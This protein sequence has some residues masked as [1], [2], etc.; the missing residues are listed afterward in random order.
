MRP[1]TDVAA[2][3]VLLKEG[4]RPASSSTAQMTRRWFSHWWRKKWLLLVCLGCFLIYLSLA[5]FRGPRQTK[6]VPGN[7]NIHRNM[8]EFLAEKNKNIVTNRVTFVTSHPHLTNKP[9]TYEPPFTTIPETQSSHQVEAS[10]TVNPL[11]TT[12][13]SLETNT[14]FNSILSIISRLASGKQLSAKTTY[15]ALKRPSVSQI[16][17]HVKD[18]SSLVPAYLS[19][20][21]RTGVELVLGIPTVKRPKQNYLR[22]TLKRLLGTMSP[23]EKNRT[24]IVILIAEVDKR[25]VSR[26]V[27][28][29]HTTFSGD[30][31]SGLIDIVSPPGSFYPDF[32][33]LPRATGIGDDLQR[34]TWRS[35]QNLDYGFLMMFALDRGRYY[36]QL[37]DDVL[38]KNGFVSTVLQFAAEKT[39]TNPEWIICDFCELGF[40]GKLFKSTDLAWLVE[41]FLIF[42]KDQPCDWLIMRAIL[43]K[44]C[45]FDEPSQKC[46]ARKNQVWLSHSNSLFQ[47]IG[48]ISSLPGKIQKLKSEHFG[49]LQLFKPHK[50]PEANTQTSISEI[51]GTYHTIDAAYRGRNFFWGREP[52]SKDYI[53][54]RFKRP[55]NL[56]RYFLQSGN[57]EHPSDQFYETDVVVYPENGAGPISIGSF[58]GEGIASGLVPN[59]VNPITEFKLEVRKNSENDV[60]LSEILLET[61][62]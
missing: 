20:K 42:F 58:D 29:I 35:K 11:V 44:V 55:I 45:R 18:D 21:G 34:F 27:G 22:V 6:I 33:A 12:E 54:F 49:K 56:T 25:F 2:K 40:I 36:M 59:E 5:S 23:A 4:H 37:E 24:L 32:A 8:L 48:V 41:V 38:S 9:S 46:T 53:S 15:P 7:S 39:R 28:D 31:E 19:S 61:A 14:N 57:L 1:T 30:V 3:K 60:I 43:T 62:S 10:S 17:P 50:N 13:T 51:M 16:L 47:H 52:K 26:I